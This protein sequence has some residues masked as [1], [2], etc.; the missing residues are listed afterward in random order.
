[1]P[2]EV[3]HEGHCCR[4]DWRSRRSQT[5]EAPDPKAGPNEVVVKLHAAGVNFIDIYHRRGSYPK[6][7][8]FIPGLEASGVVESL[9]AG[10]TTAKVG[11]RVA[12]TG[13]P[14]SYAEKSV[15]PAEKLFAVP[16]SMSFEDA[17]AV[18]LQGSD[19]AVSG[20]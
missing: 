9:G 19:R 18:P 1:M 7:L 12:Y 17:A 15:V 20:A 6:T 13:V 10:V 5:G 16:A 4:E 14:G 3:N 2:I 11:D 8:P